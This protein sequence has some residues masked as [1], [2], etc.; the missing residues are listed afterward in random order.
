MSR[1][2]EPSLRVEGGDLV[3]SPYAGGLSDRRVVVG[4]VVRK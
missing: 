1:Y 4:I 3:I 2:H